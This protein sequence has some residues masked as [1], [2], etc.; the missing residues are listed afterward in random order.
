[1]SFDEV[2]FTTASTTRGSLALGERY[3]PDCLKL[4]SLLI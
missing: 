1:M 3:N 4:S 2:K